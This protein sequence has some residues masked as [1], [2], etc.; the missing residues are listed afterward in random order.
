MGNEHRNLPAISRC[1]ISTNDSALILV[2]GAPPQVAVIQRRLRDI[3]SHD[4]RAHEISWLDRLTHPR[5]TENSSP[6]PHAAIRVQL[7]ELRK[8]TQHESR[9]SAHV[10]TTDR[11]ERNRVTLH[12]KWH[13]NQ[14]P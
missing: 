8:I 10:R 9:T 5:L 11:I 13:A 2:R 3:R 6:V 4:L 1:V 12:L 14:I 7:S